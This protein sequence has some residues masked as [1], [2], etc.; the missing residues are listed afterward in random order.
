MPF[1]LGTAAIAEIFLY[2]LWKYYIGSN[3]IINQHI[4]LDVEVLTLPY[5]IFKKNCF[6]IDYTNSIYT[7]YFVL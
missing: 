7:P 5:E 4:M 3:L 6:I 1:T 2:S